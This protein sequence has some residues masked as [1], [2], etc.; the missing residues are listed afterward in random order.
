LFDEGRMVSEVIERYQPQM[1]A[2]ADRFAMGAI[3]VLDDIATPRLPENILKSPQ[4]LTEAVTLTETRD[5]LVIT[6]PN[7]EG[8]RLELDV[9]KL[10][11]EAFFPALV[12]YDITLGYRVLEGYDCLKGIRINLQDDKSNIHTNKTIWEGELKQEEVVTF[13]LV[14]GSKEKEETIGL[15]LFMALDKGPVTLEITQLDIK[16]TKPEE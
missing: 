14:Y 8:K 9:C 2:A 12:Y 4:M 3:T 6:I 13:R 15:Y 10:G 11:G 5:G 1:Q 16:G 7:P